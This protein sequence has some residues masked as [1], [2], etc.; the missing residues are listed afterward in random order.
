VV[1]FDRAYNTA[2]YANMFKSGI[3][4]NSNWTGWRG[5]TGGS[6][7]P[8]VSC[9]MPSAGSL[10]CGILYLVDSFMYAA[11]FDG[12]NWSSFAKMGTKPIIAGPACGVLSSGKV[13]CAVVGLNNQALS[14]TGP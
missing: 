12:T 6:I 3:W 11:T 1:C 8:R 14:T 10:A 2:I 13:L 4:Q 9:A 7:G 5:I